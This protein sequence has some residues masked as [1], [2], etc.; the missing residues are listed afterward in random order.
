LH[1]TS[2]EIRGNAPSLKRRAGKLK[3][4]ENDGDGR[5]ESV[6]AVK[7]HSPYK[8]FRQSSGEAHEIT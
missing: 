2:I 3:K 7:T 1:P 8:L 5:S 4:G 6:Q